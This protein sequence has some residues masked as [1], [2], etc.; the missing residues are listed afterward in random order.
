MGTSSPGSK[1]SLISHPQTV[2]NGL[3]PHTKSRGLTCARGRS[4]P[5]RK[6]QKVFRRAT[7]GL[8]LPLVHEDRVHASQDSRVRR[9]QSA[10]PVVRPRGWPSPG[11]CHGYWPRRRS[12][13]PSVSGGQCPAPAGHD[14]GCHR[15]GHRQRRDLSVLRRTRGH[16]R[17]DIP[18]DQLWYDPVGPDRDLRRHRHRRRTDDHRG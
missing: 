6:V 2:H 17:T 1:V 14:R 4:Y 13:R 15:D 18:D 8:L 7:R 11:R 16:G 9:A 12:G 10:R 3:P 5:R